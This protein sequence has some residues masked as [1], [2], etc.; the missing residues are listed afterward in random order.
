M[1]RLS[2]VLNIQTSRTVYFS[3]F[4]SLVNYGILFWG[5]TSSMHKVSLV[6][7]G[8]KNYV[9]IKFMEFLQKMV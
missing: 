2:P 7:K 3:H 4:Q 9:E 8:I 5:N 1:R 6:K